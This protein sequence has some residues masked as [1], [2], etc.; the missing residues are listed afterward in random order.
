MSPYFRLLRIGLV[1]LAMLGE[2]SG[3]TAQSVTPEE[4]VRSVQRMLERLPYYSER[5]G[6]N[7]LAAAGVTI[8]R[9]S[10]M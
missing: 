1:G 8:T 5:R 4:T 10:Q 2:T 7:V 6:K 3:A 9:R